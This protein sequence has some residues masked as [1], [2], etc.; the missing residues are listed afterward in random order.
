MIAFT[1]I[2]L[3]ADGSWAFT[4]ANDSAAYWR[5]VLAGAV[6]ASNLTTP[7]YT[8]IGPGYPEFPPPLE[9]VDTTNLALSEQYSSIFTL[10]WYAVP[11]AA[12]YQ[13]QQYTGGVWNTIATISDLSQWVYT[14][15]T[16]VLV[17]GTTY[18]LR[19]AACDALGDQGTP[20]QYTRL[21][22]CPPATPDGHTATTYVGS[23]IV[24]V[25]S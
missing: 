16:P 2:T 4:W 24:I 1:G 14:Y 5:V 13:V 8:W 3:N 22:V 20:R 10:Q 12:Y 6:I 7:S 25:T 19:V 11:N 15:S 17:D 9:V 21:V 23:N 18:Q